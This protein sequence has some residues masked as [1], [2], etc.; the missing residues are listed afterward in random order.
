[1][2]EADIMPDHYYARLTPGGPLVPAPPGA[3]DKRVCRR[4][5]DYPH[6]VP[7]ARAAIAPCA[8]CRALVA[9]NPHGPH[10]DKPPVCM[11]CCGIQPLPIEEPQ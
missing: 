10:L 2:K 5:T 11:Q 8:E 4:V 6:G 1:M 3:V 7:P 9:F